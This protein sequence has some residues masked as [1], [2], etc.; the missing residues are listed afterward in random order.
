MAESGRGL[1]GSIRRECLDH[2]IVFNQTHLRRLL[3]I[4]SRYYHRRRTQDSAVP[5]TNRI[6]SRKRSVTRCAVPLVR[7]A[8]TLPAQSL[9]GRMKFNLV[10][11]ACLPESS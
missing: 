8:S 1:I 9:V 5:T 4:Y 2:V 6:G 7:E 10:S 3:T 11:Q